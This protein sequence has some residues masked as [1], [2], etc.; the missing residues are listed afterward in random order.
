MTELIQQIVSGLSL[1]LVYA[2]LALA[3][4]VIVRGT[5]VMNFA[6]GEM[7]TFSAFLAWALI[8]A[9]VGFWP[10]L[11]LVLIGSF[12]LGGIVERVF[13]RPVE[14]APELSVVTV[15]IALFLLFNG[16]TGVIWGYLP[17]RFDS[18][19]GGGAYDVFGVFVTHHQVGSAAVLLVVLGA[20]E[21]LF[22]RT[23]MGLR[24][25]AAAQNPG[26]SQLLGIPVGWMLALGWGVAAVV[27]GVAGVM[28]APT[29]GQLDPNTMSPV[30]LFA[31][32]GAALGGFESRIGAVVGGLMMGVAYSLTRRYVPGFEDQLTVGVPFIVILV[33]LLVRPQGLFGRASAAR[34]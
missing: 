17:H 16:L 2:G 20:T 18:P 29:A 22:R 10:A 19:F 31:F 24:L 1:G 11:V 28:A 7:A 15:A 13:I 27:G 21:L 6:Q 30:L 23:D 5:G 12:L 25:R 3:L 33:V 9:G 8:S 32:A 4:S 26:S 14:R 34:A